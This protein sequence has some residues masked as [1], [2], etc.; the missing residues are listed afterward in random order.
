MAMAV[1]CPAQTQRAHPVLQPVAQAAARREG[2]AS[3]C[4]ATEYRSLAQHTVHTC[5]RQAAHTCDDQASV[6]PPFAC[7]NTRSVRSGR[8]GAA[9]E[10]EKTHSRP[11]EVLSFQRLPSCV[12]TALAALLSSLTARRLPLSPGFRHLAHAAKTV[13]LV[14][15][16]EAH[17]R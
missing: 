4:P 8:R 6:V 9:A 17:E 7:V 16:Q 13:A 3:P 1:A 5:A 15:R 12:L 14:V 2:P 11:E 10:L